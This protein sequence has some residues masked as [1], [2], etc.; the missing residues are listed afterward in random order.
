MSNIIQ[1]SVSSI[2]HTAPPSFMGLDSSESLQ[3]GPM[4]HVSQH[5]AG[6]PIAVPYAPGST[7]FYQYAQNGM[8]Y[9][10]NYNLAYSAQ[11]AESSCPRSYNGIDPTGLP[12]DISMSESY[13]PAAYQIEPQRHHDSMDLSDHEIN[14]QLMQ[15]S[16]DYEHHPYSPRIKI[17][18]YND[19]Q[20]PYSNLTRA[21]TPQNDAPR[22]PH[23]GNGDDTAID[24][25]QPYAQLIYQALLQAPEKTMILRDI[26]DWFKKYTDK[27]AASETKG[28]QNSIRH[29]LSMNGVR[30]LQFT[31]V[32]CPTL[33]TLLP[34]QPH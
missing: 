10:D 1:Q 26:Y 24:K 32:T 11:Y 27:A 16:N 13:P 2:D 18:E 14:G 12:N 19:Y 28:W 34:P 17:E 23:D 8:S 33:L 31:A 7:E 3:W 22:Y 25:E 20:S 6:Y 29:N 15:L 30:H 9:H 21:S 4:H 5:T